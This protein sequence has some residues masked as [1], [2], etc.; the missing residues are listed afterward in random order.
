MILDCSRFLEV[1]CTVCGG[2]TEAVG[3]G[4]RGERRYWCTDHSHCGHIAY[5]K[6]RRPRR[7]GAGH[8]HHTPASFTS[9]LRRQAWRD[10]AIGDLATD[11]GL[12][13]NW[14]RWVRRFERTKNYLTSR[15]ACQ[16]ALMALAAAWR[17]WSLVSA[18]HTPATDAAND[19]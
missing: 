15:G 13:P 11:V 7:P 3:P 2:P 9:W 12:D 8:R 5:V 14:P 18:Q 17:E 10:D 16:A 1:R 19:Q 6:A 4:L